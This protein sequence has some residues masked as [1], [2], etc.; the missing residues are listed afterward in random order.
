MNPCLRET[1]NSRKAFSAPSR[2]LDKLTKYFIMGGILI[3]A[4]VGCLATSVSGLPSPEAGSFGILGVVALVL[5][6]IMV[7][8]ALFI[9]LSQLSKERS[10]PAQPA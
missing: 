3:I 8:S 7:I 5:G 9:D 6:L 10:R 4:G 2:S 1:L